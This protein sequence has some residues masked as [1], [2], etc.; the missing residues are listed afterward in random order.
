MP[1]AFENEDILLAGGCIFSP[2]AIRFIFERQK[3]IVA[4]STH[5]GAIPESKSWFLHLPTV[6]L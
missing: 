2:R 4:M 1:V 6:N 5:F 3:S